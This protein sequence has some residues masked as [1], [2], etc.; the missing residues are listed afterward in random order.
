MAGGLKVV[1]IALRVCGY[2]N[3]G[4]TARDRWTFRCEKPR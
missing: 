2:E 4:V 3:T 1:E